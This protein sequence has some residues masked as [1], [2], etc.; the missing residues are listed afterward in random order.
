MGVPGDAQPAVAGDRPSDGALWASFAETLRRVV[1]PQLEDAWA[2]AQAI[3]L[4]GLAQ[5]ARGRGGDPAHRY[6]DELALALESIADNPLV[7][8]HWPGEPYAVAGAALAA[9]VPRDDA[10]ADEVRAVLRPLLVGQLDEELAM[11]SP[12]MDAFRGRLP[13]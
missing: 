6:T 2:R 1:L 4:I 7:R 9:A 5:Q 10:V 11:S 3:Q 12:L 13:S 8:E